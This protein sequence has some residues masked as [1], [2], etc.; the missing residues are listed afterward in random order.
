MRN[1]NTYIWPTVIALALAVGIFIGG[2]LHFKDSPE[3]LFTTNSK[4][5]SSIG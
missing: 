1:K 4:K 3:K 2:K 5:P